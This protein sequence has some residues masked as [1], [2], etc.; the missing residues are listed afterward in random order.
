M[1][2]NKLLLRLFCFK[3]DKDSKKKGVAFPQLLA[4]ISFPHSYFFS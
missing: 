3:N 2:L 4:R 1:A